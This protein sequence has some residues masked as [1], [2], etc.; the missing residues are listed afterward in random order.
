MLKLGSKVLGGTYRLSVADMLGCA[1]GPWEESFNQYN[2]LRAWDLIGVVPFTRRVYWELLEAKAKRA[3]VALDVNIDPEL[4]TVH[5]MVKI[6]FPSAVTADQAGRLANGKR[7]RDTLNSS[8]LW[9]KPG[10]ATADDCFAIVERKT[11]ER[12]AKVNRAAQKKKKTTEAR[13]NEEG[14]KCQRFRT[15]RSSSTS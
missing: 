14:G 1:K 3:A 9:D 5:N 6:L 15:A 10:G 7:D 13:Q 12:N 4:L 2:C 11:N 8:D